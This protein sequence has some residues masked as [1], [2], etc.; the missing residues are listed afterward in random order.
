MIQRT[1]LPLFIA[2]SAVG[3]SSTTEEPSSDP[4]AAASIT[5]GGQTYTTSVS[6]SANGSITTLNGFDGSLECVLGILDRT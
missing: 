2:V 3:C 5:V 1:L 4:N 6:R